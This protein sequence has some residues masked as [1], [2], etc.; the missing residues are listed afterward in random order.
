[1]ITGFRGKDQVTAPGDLNGDGRNDLAARNPATGALVLFLQRA[2][3]TFR[4]V[5]AG[6]RWSSYDLHL[7]RP[8]TSTVTASPTWWPATRPASSGCTPATGTRLRDRGSRCP[9]SFG[10]YDAITGGGDFTAGRPATSSSAS[11]PP[12]DT[13]VLPGR[14]DGTFGQPARDR[15]PGSPRPPRPAVGNVGGNSAPDV[16]A[17]VGDTV[18]V[19]VNPGTF[20]LGPPIDTGVSF[21]GAD[22][23]LDVGDW[24]RDG[25]GDVVTRQAVD[26][27]PGAVA[28]RRARPPD[29]RRGAR[30]GFGSVV[31]LAAV[32]DMT[33]DG[34]PDLIGQPAGR[35]H[36]DLPRPRPG[37]A[38]E[39]LPGVRVDQRRPQIGV[40][41]WNDDGAPDS[42]LRHGGTLTLY[43]GNGPGGLS[44]PAKLPVDL[45]PLRLGDRGQRP[46]G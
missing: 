34:Y 32:G 31:R 45:S 27:Q 5:V 37:R 42:L 24:D 4:H 39:G 22:R 16:V 43:P 40:G 29:P 9:G 14:G 8:G 35:R 23:I 26:R 18:Q 25:Y 12:G 15:S 2:D 11:A 28:R 3:G 36:D 46:H 1:M 17:L 38:E 10:R 44:R 6:T 33:G 41:R 7:G 13:Y 19:W 21:A 20:D 30:P